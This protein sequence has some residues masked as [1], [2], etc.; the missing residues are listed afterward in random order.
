MAS[1]TLE[2][3]QSMITVNM[4]DYKTARG[5]KKLITKDLGSCV[6][7]AMWDSQTGV[8]G[9]L[10]IMLPQYIPNRTETSFIAAKYAD[11]GLEE[12]VKV[13]VQQGAGRERLAAKLA[14]AAHMV[15][16]D[17]VPES[18]DISSRNLAA[19]KKKLAELKIPVL[20]YEVG[21]YYPRTVVFEPGSGT[22]RIVTPGKADKI[23]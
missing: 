1:F 4:G 23:L 7:I 10:H 16:V 18:R 17:Q 13:L 12:M 3:L 14:G 6:G 5:D 2:E 15:K 9:L 19:V 22:F 8:G 20:A 11:T 21:D